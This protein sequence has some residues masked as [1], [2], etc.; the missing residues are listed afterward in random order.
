MFAGISGGETSLK[1]SLSLNILRLC[2]LLVIIGFFLPVACDLSGYQMAQGILGH[3]QKAQNAKLLESIEDS[4]GYFLFG[5]PTLAFLGLILTFAVKAV[6]GYHFGLLSL[7]VSFLFLGVVAL[8]FQ[9]LR[10]T[11]LLHFFIATFHL[12]VK[13]LLGGYSMA[14]GYLAGVIGYALRMSKLIQ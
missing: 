13:I 12:R 1:Q 5:V 6:S 3:A 11:P 9:S 10:N 2:L 4:Y 14:T 8:K 7:A